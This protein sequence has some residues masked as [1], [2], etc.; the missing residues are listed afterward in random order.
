[1]RSCF[2]VP[3]VPF[4]AAVLRAAVL[5][6]LAHERDVHAWAADLIDRSSAW[7]SRLADLLATPIE[8]SATRAALWPIAESASAD[9]V[10]A[11]VLTWAA[12][13]SGH[14]RRDAA[15]FV[16]LLDQIR[17]ECQLRQD[18]AAAIKALQQREWL[19]RAAMRGNIAPSA[20]EIHAWLEHAREPAHFIFP[21]GDG[22]QA[23]AFLAA[24]SRQI[25][26]NRLPILPPHR[27]PARAWIAAGRDAPVV[28]LNEAAWRAAA[29]AFAPLPVGGR[30]PYPGRV[31]P[32]ARPLLDEAN[33][34]PL[35]I[36]EVIAELNTVRLNSE[37]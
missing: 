26:G 5:V 33:A 31:D 9:R 27:E 21:F 8:L 11:S 10:G 23:A 32:S 36:D 14:D 6:G 3:D 1:M 29:Q 2:V 19:A 12:I 15:Q 13:D 7:Q 24:L 16:N 28:L 34:R 22:C 17:Q 35:G 25:A 20:A 18:E 30:I 4:E 37:P